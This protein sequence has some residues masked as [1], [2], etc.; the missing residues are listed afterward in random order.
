MNH[1]TQDLLLEYCH[2]DV[3]RPDTWVSVVCCAGPPKGGQGVGTRSVLGGQT[4]ECRLVGSHIM[5]PA[6]TDCLDYG[7]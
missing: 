2:T 5:Y 7:S 6:G 4:S 3:L 1:T